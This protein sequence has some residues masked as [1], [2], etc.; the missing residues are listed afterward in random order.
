MEMRINYLV[1]TLYNMS[2]MRRRFKHVNRIPVTMEVILWP[3]G[4]VLG[5]RNQAVS[6]STQF[7]SSKWTITNSDLNRPCFAWRPNGKS[8]LFKTDLVIRLFVRRCHGQALVI[9]LESPPC[10]HV[11]IYYSV[12]VPTLEVFNENQTLSQARG[13]WQNAVKESEKKQ[14]DNIEKSIL[15]AQIWC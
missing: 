12:C 15:T 11:T 13:I 7:Q 3:A 4:P 8:V 9:L 10:W 6:Y 1:P 2:K 5:C 14:E